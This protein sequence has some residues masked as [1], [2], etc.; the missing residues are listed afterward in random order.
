V[1]NKL[2]QQVSGARTDFRQHGRK[3]LQLYWSFL[4]AQYEN[5]TT[6]IF[7]I[8]SFLPRLLV[9]SNFGFGTLQIFH[10]SCLLAIREFKKENCFKSLR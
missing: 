5:P 9:K 8:D 10:S 7:F 1:A 4:I 2:L 6:C 3:K